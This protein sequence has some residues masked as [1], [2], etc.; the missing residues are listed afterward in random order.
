[1]NGVAERMNRKLVER[2]KCLFSK[3]EL[4]KLFGAEAF[5]TIV[6]VPSLSPCLSLQYEVQEIRGGG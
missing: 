6:Q 2:V 4:P 5:N 3:K 1:L